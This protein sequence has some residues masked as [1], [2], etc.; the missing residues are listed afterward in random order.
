MSDTITDWKAFI[1]GKRADARLSQSEFAARFKINLRTL[2]NWE[3][4]RSKP[5]PLLRPT[6]LKKVS[7]I[8]G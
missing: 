1:A 8:H 6:L 7:K 5:H 3:C 2:Q 4:G